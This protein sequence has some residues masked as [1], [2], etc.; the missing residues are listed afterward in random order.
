MDCNKILSLQDGRVC[1]FN[2]PCALLTGHE[3]SNGLFK[4]L[5]DET[6]P[7][8]SRKLITMATD[9]ASKQLL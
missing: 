1:E 3:H 6:G 7:D 2:T 5:V 9:A 4:S 8:T